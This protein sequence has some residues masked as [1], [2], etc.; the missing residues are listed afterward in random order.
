MTLNEY[1]VNARCNGRSCE[2]PRAIRPAC[3]CV[4][5]AARQLRRM[6]HVKA[7]RPAKVHQVAESDEVVD[8]PV[9]AKEGATLGEHD[10]LAAS[11]FQL[12]DDMSHLGWREE[13]PLLHVDR[14][15]R[16]RARSQQI[17]L[18][19]QKGGHLQEINDLCC[20][21]SLGGLVNVGR[22]WTANQRP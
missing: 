17:S 3:R 15:T 7:D 13:L 1:S 21:R 9:V 22:H 4:C 6:G 16:F 2:Q 19:A 11:V 14:F 5:A 8:E 10:V 12:L 18:P 20:L